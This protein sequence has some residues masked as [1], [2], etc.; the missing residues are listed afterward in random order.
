MTR[1]HVFTHKQYPQQSHYVRHIVESANEDSSA[2]LKKVGAP[3]AGVLFLRAR[4][5]AA[6]SSARKKKSPPSPRDFSPPSFRFR[7]V[8]FSS[9]IPA[10]AR[11]AD[12]GDAIHS[13]AIHSARNPCAFAHKRGKQGFIKAALDLQG[14]PS[15][16]GSKEKMMK[17]LWTFMNDEVDFPEF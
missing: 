17:A 3:R 8:V 12:V 9:S 6:P 11:V 4:G 7:K 16:Q 10:D 14:I 1:V 5:T 15:K 13:V 2:R